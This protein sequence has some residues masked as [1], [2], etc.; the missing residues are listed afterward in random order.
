[1]MVQMPIG[2]GSMDRERSVPEPDIAVVTEVK[3]SHKTRLVR[4]DELSLV[5]EV[6]D[7]SVRFDA[8][9]KRDLY[10][11][12]GVPEY[13][14]LDVPG[15]SLVVHRQLFDDRYSDVTIL[16]GHAGIAPPSMPEQLFQVSAILP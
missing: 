10:A 15:G 6:G 1:M 8:T 7:T 4:G 2:A 11:R 16:S 14:V 12:A 9:V 5:I 3:E 13:W